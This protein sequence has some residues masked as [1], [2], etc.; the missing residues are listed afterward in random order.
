MVV[1][2]EELELEKKLTLQMERTRIAGEMHDEIGSGL[3]TIRN[4]SA[5]ASRKNNFEDCFEVSKGIRNSYMNEV[6]K[7]NEYALFRR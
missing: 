3:S 7:V 2:E 1:E 4:A 5:K 6:E